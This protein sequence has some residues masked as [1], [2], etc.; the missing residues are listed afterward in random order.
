MKRTLTICIVLI[1]GL[2]TICESYDVFRAKRL[3]I[4]KESGIENKILAD[5]LDA[6][7]V[8]YPTPGLRTKSTN[9]TINGTAPTN[10]DAVLLQIDSG[11]WVNASG[12]QTWI[13][14]ASGMTS[15]SH[16]IIAKTRNKYGE[17]ACAAVSFMIDL[18]APVVTVTSGHSNSMTTNEPFYVT[19]SVD[20][21]Y[22]YCSFN[23][24]SFSSFSTNGTNILIDRN[25][26]LYYYGHDGLNSS[27]TNSVTYNVDYTIY[28]APQASGGNNANSGI[29]PNAPVGT[30]AQAMYLLNNYGAKRLYL[31]KG[32]YSYTN[33]LQV[34]SWSI[35]S[36]QYQ[37]YLNGAS[38]NNVSI[39]GGWDS[40]FVLRT[41]GT[42]R[43]IFL[44]TNGGIILV[45]GA[46]NVFIEG[47]N[48]MAGYNDVKGYGL[49][50]ES[51]T[52]IIVTNFAS[53]SNRWSTGLNHGGGIT[54][55]NSKDIAFH[56]ESSWTAQY[57]HNGGGIFIAKSEYVTIV[58]KIFNNDSGSRSG[59]GIYVDSGKYI[60]LDIECY[61][62]VTTG[63]CGGAMLVSGMSN[64]IKGDI[65]NNTASSVGGVLLRYEANSTLTGSIFSNCATAIGSRGGGLSLDRVISNTVTASIFSNSSGEFG[66]GINMP[67][68]TNTTVSGYVMNN[69]DRTVTSGYGSGI[70]IVDGSENIISDCIITNNTTGGAYNSQLNMLYF[71]SMSIII[72][73]CRFAGGGLSCS[74]IKEDGN[75]LAG[76]TLINNI[77]MTNN[78][79]YLYSDYIQSP[80]SINNVAYLNMPNDTRHDASVATNNMVTN[81]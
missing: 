11:A 74:A 54:I 9:M 49:C 46:T 51:A 8:L 33:E 10:A 22:G 2:G 4:L 39:V 34:F 80:I 13:F 75:D 30:I 62:N 25:R 67:Y 42:N 7:K 15:G 21:S 56:G 48:A 77:F 23:G 63:E 29:K 60:S 71:V 58:G 81:Q 65:Y 69:I 16:S 78:M 20:E 45:R 55:S 19:L 53:I 26:T 28:V 64:R 68:C 73:N 5:Q 24:V 76:H 44:C 50:I 31:M 3:T 32:I 70:Q 43:S 1:A 27:L 47:I 37:I 79:L 59:G 57:Y 40:N 72:S 41:D 12:V 52:N 36:E 14:S 61:N 35:P 38:F 6:P 66:S 17:N 18:H